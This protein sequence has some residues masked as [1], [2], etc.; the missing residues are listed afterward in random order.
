MIFL[1]ML[2]SVALSLSKMSATKRFLT[3]RSCYAANFSSSSTLWP[4]IASIDK[5]ASTGLPESIEAK[6]MKLYPSDITPDPTIVAKQARDYYQPVYG[7]LRHLLKLKRSAG[8]PGPVLVGISAPQGCGKTTLTDLMQELFREHD[9]ASVAVMS[10]DDFYL[11]AVDQK[12]LKEKYMGNSL[13]E[14]RGNAGT[15]D[16]ELMMDTVKALQSGEKC[17]IPRYDKSVNGGKGDRAAKDEWA[18]FDKSPDIVLFEGWMLG[19]DPVPAEALKD[20]EMQV[21]NTYLQGYKD[22]HASF[23]GWLVVGLSSIDL[24]YKW[25]QHAESKMIA[26]GKTGMSE[27]EVRDFINRFMPSY[28]HYLPSLYAQGPKWRKVDA[29]TGKAVSALLV[30]INEDRMPQFVKEL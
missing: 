24:V 20:E 7:Y 23:D 5:S 8:T 4:E 19:F 3:G 16:M 6:L 25:R 17:T 28:E 29:A 15:H 27:A 21:V 9:D 12:T 18:S 14:L 13:V 30:T 11:T 10:L 26:S 22:L 2:L 1:A